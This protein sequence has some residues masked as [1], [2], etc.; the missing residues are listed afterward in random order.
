MKDNI[1]K[2]KISEID[3]FMNHPFRVNQDES[4]NELIES[5]KNN[6]LLN[7]IIVR[8]KNNRYEL[9]SGHRRKEVMELLGKEYIEAIIKDLNDDEATIEMV[10][11][12][13][14]REKVLPSEKAFAYK[15]K[16]DAIKHQGKRS[17]TGCQK[18]RDIIG[19]E[20]G[21][22]IQNYIRLTN[23]IPEILKLVDDTVLYNKK[24]LLTMGI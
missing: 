21:R 10:D 2:I 12:N 3:R 7:P 16:L 17:G 8:K 22:Q 19:L 15:M 23:L 9:I 20:S 11:S 14:Y 6:G 1:V 13:I 24:N 4:F 18:S 5:I